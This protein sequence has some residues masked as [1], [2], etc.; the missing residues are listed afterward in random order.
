MKLIINA[1]KYLVT[2]GIG[3]FLFYWVFKDH[4]WIDLQ[5]SIQQIN[6][7]LILLCFI[8]A[9]G[10]HWFRGVRWVMLIKPLGDTVTHKNAFMAVMVGYLANLAVP[11]MGEVSR[12]VVIN[13]TNGT[14][15]DKLIGTVVVE[16]LADVVSLLIILGLNLVLEFDKLKGFF[17]D[18][19]N[20][21]QADK[22][23]YTSTLIIVALVLVLGLGLIIL[24]LTK[25][26]HIKIVKKFKDILQ[27]FAIGFNTIRQLENKWKF[28]FY[29]FL[30]WL[31]YYLQVYICFLAFPATSHLGPLPALSVLNM[32]SFGFV[33]PVQGGIGAYHWIVQKTLMLY[34]IDE[35]TAKDFAFIAHTF[36]I[37]VIL[38]FGFISLLVLSSMYKKIKNNKLINEASQS[39]K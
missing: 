15:V 14:K 5:K 2:L 17:V 3:V 36:Q 20:N 29:T 24:I 22:T 7:F 1:L 38:I 11:R 18:Y 25:F 23:D 13:R 27:N 26:K 4:K 32:G 35:S 10:S 31:L 8:I 12:C 33:A 37:L 34:N 28:L 39:E 6:P 21:R 9:V 30:I 19:L 16:R